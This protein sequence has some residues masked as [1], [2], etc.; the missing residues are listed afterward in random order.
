MEVH[1]SESDGSEEKACEEIK[2]EFRITVRD[3]KEKK[4]VDAMSKEDLAKE[5]KEKIAASENIT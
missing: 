1:V 5:I 4:R 2:E 3:E